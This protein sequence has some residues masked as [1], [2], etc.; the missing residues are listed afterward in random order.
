MPETTT[1]LKAILSQPWAYNLAL[2]ILGSD[3][4]RRVL[5][6]RYIKAKP[7]DRVLDIGCG[8]AEIIDHMPEVKYT[9]YDISEKYIDAA[10]ERYPQHTF[11]LGA[12]PGETEGLYDIVLAIGVL[13]HLSQQECVALLQSARAHLAPGGRIVTLDNCRHGNPLEWVMYAL[14]RGQNILNERGYRQLA[15]EAGVELADCDVNSHISA[16]WLPYTYCIMTMR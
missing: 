8:T 1:G 10:R 16:P 4:G 2:R 11:R 3:H 14:D 7:G 9:G 12:L 13:H 15:Q 5:A 6:E